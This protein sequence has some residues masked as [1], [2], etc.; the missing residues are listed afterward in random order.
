MNESPF[1]PPKAG[2][3]LTSSRSRA[4]EGSPSAGQ[5]CL[6][7]GGPKHGEHLYIPDDLDRWELV[8]SNLLAG[9]DY[10]KL[11]SRYQGNV[12]VRDRKLSGA[13]G[14]EVF[15]HNVINGPTHGSD[16][17]PNLVG[18]LN[19]V[20]AADKALRAKQQIVSDRNKEITL[21]AA[22]IKTLNSRVDESE[23]RLVLLRTLL[24]RIAID[25]V[26]AVD[27]TGKGYQSSIASAES[28]EA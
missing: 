22:T 13:L 12:Y 19:K 3:P 1:T 2:F 24:E 16:I 27:A 18:A 15:T 25:V 23:K 10:S 8:E 11:D 4:E 21:A 17:L 26:W 6:L 28:P 9:L 14:R 7:I 20:E 5:R